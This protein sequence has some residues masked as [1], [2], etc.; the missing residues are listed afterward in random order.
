MEENSELCL[1]KISFLNNLFLLCSIF[2]LVIFS[3]KFFSSKEF[4]R[5]MVT[6]F[7]KKSFKSCKLD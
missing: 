3:S 7:S 6:A 1:T 4:N 5:W 2:D